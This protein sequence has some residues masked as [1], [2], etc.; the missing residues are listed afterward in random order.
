MATLG[1]NILDS[2]IASK[3]FH[4]FLLHG[5]FDMFMVH[6]F[7]FRYFQNHVPVSVY[8]YTSFPDNLSKHGSSF[9]PA[10][11]RAQ[12]ADTELP[13]PSCGQRRARP[14]YTGL[15]HSRRWCS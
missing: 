15:Y 6:L 14:R 11:E 4:C 7:N 10:G 3:M 8:F 1:K 12:A 2:G 9:M 13:S 5:H